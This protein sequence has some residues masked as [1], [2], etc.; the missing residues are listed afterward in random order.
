MST[1]TPAEQFASTLQALVDA[2]LED[3]HVT[4]PGRIESYDRDHQR[5]SVQPLIKRVYKDARGAIKQK[6]YPVCTDVPVEFVGGGDYALTFPVAK[7][8]TCRLVFCSAAID[9][10]LALGGEQSPGDPRRFSLTDAVCVVGLRDFAHA[11]KNLPSN[12]WV[13]AAP[14]GAHILLGGTS[15]SE[16]AILGD[17]WKSAH[18]TMVTAI[19]TAVSGI[20]GGGAGAATAITNA[21]NAFNAATWLAAKVR[22]E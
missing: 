17:A 2:R 1:P 15:A 9:R 20:A 19:A 3:V 21:L 11:L 10:F 4:M 12:A 7:G 5:A 22:L 14:T 6:S 13:M 18:S 8:M 16:K